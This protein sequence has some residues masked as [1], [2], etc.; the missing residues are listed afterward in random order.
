MKIEEEVK[1]T[2][3]LSKLRENQLKEMTVSED[4][5][6][7]EMD[8]DFDFSRPR[9]FPTAEKQRIEVPIQLSEEAQAAKDK[10]DAQRRE[11]TPV[12]VCITV[13]STCPWAVA[14]ALEAGAK[15]R[16]RVVPSMATIKYVRACVRV[17]V[18]VCVCMRVYVSIL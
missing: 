13:S 16:F 15:L 1:P 4:I 18:C 12:D 2:M 14:G 8:A 10:A 5:I 9:V 11:L 6:S 17:C 7:Q 3:R